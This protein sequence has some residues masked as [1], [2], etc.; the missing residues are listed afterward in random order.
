MHNH[1]EYNPISFLKRT[2]LAPTETFNPQSKTNN[3]P[4]H[5]QPTLLKL[6]NHQPSQQV[7]NRKKKNEP[8]PPKNLPVPVLCFSHITERS[9]VKVAC[10]QTKQ[11]I[12]L[13]N[14]AKYKSNCKTEI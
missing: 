5:D 4:T 13:L 14:V 3:Q 11:V 12:R 6:T 7:T 2:P 10:L 8:N 9:W 1:T